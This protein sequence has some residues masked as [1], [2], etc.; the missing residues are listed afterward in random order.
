MQRGYSKLAIRNLRMATPDRESIDLIVVPHHPRDPNYPDDFGPDYA[1]VYGFELALKNIGKTVA[2]TRIDPADVF[3]GGSRDSSELM[4]RVSRAVASAVEKGSFPIV[5]AGNGTKQIG[6]SAELMSED[7][8]LIWFDAHSVFDIRSDPS[9]GTQILQRKLEGL[10]AIVP[11]HQLPLERLIYCGTREISEVHTQKLKESSARVVCGNGIDYTKALVEQLGKT[12][13]ST[14][15][16]HVDLDC[17]DTT[18]DKT[19]EYAATG[20]FGVS[21]LHHCIEAIAAR[22]RSSALL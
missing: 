21:D 7:L 15:F 13:A 17:L 5:L 10:T 4:R 19:G 18:I 11:E 3:N 16:V 22:R 9:D 14:C 2:T 20:R 8:D 6:V 12:A 1:V